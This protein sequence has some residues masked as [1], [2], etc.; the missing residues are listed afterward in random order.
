MTQRAAKG[1]GSISPYA[2]GRFR[3]RATINGI[4]KTKICS[5]EREAER[6]VFRWQ[7]EAN[8]GKLVAGTKVILENAIQ[9]W[10][11]DADHLAL[12]TRQSYKQKLNGYIRHAPIGKLKLSALRPVDIENFLK[13][14][15]NGKFAKEKT[16]FLNK[17]ISKL[18][19][20][21]ALYHQKR[22]QLVAQLPENDHFEYSRSVQRQC[23]ALI[24]EA[25]KW[26]AGTDRGWVTRNVALDVTPPSAVTNAR[27]DAGKPGAANEK[28]GYV[29]PHEHLM[30]ILDAAQNDRLRLRWLLALDLGLRIGEVLGLCWGDLDEATGTL[31]IRRQVQ[32]DVENGRTVIVPRV[33]TP[34]G[35]REVP[36]P[37]YLISE[38]KRHA[39]RQKREKEAAGADWEQ[40]T[41]EGHAYDL[42]FRQTNGSV[43]SS[44]LDHTYWEKLL[45]KTK[46]VDPITGITGPVPHVRRYVARH[47][48]ASRMVAM[49]NSDILSIAS[50]LGHSSADFTLRKYSHALDQKKRATVQGLHEANSTRVHTWLASKADDSRHM[51][52]EERWAYENPEEAA[53]KEQWATEAVQSDEAD[54][55]QRAESRAQMIRAMNDQNVD[56][57]RE[58][59]S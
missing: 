7:E 9:A 31:T 4:T 16:K 59:G 3:V 5:T 38:W 43:I 14:L 6:Q 46:A 50:I 48:A 30:A 52:P 22:V 19:P 47:S 53:M 13:S 24:R 57:M 35:Q 20:L 12:T 51:T 29:L 1:T 32:H 44:R 25:L 39:R 42:V 11:N 26:S 41:F 2:G 34:S 37:E 8:E 58:T 54:L 33:K 18:N 23:Y 40:W 15:S 49:P 36:M 28:H 10:L 56:R 55:R 17:E 45:K 27:R 21:E